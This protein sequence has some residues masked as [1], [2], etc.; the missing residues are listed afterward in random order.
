M[1]LFIDALTVGKRLVAV[2]AMTS[3][4]WRSAFSCC[5]QLGVRPVDWIVP[6]GC[7]LR[8]QDLVRYG[9]RANVVTT[10]LSDMASTATTIVIHGR[11]RVDAAIGYERELDKRPAAWARRNID[12]RCTARASAGLLKLPN[13][14]APAG[15]GDDQWLLPTLDQCRAHFAIHSRGVD[16]VAELHERLVSAGALE[17]A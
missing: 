2:E 6:E 8:H 1:I 15:V 13:P 3:S 10:I 4:D 7:A 16:A 12:I 9:V 5:F 17:A 11:D 14:N